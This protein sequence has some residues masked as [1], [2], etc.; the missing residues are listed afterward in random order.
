MTEHDWNVSTE[1]SAMWAVLQRTVTH[2]RGCWAVE[3]FLR[4]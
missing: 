3:L 1:P 4:S 2:V